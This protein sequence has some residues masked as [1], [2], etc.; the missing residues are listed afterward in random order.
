MAW[1]SGVTAATNLDA[2][3]SDTVTS[4][5]RRSDTSTFSETLTTSTGIFSVFS[6]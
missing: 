5:G 2:P 1:L 3:F 6:E 4:S